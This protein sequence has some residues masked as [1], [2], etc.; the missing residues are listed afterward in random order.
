MFRFLEAIFRLN[1][2]ECIYICIYI[3]IYIYIYITMP[4]NGRDLVY[5]LVYILN[6]NEISSFLWYCDIH[7]LSYVQP[8][9]GF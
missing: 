5:N 6:V 9:D 8:E 1:I 2:G 4:E 3:Y 7:T